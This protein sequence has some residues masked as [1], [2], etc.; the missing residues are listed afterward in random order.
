MFALNT[1]P[2]KAAP[3]DWPSGRPLGA[4]GG[5]LTQ[6]MIGTMEGGGEVQGGSGAP[7]RQPSF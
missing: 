1:V 3:S 4:G 7:W 5:V 6:W 2:S